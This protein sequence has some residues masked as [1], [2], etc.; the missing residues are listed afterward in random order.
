MDDDDI[1]ET[2]ET[3]DDGDL[4]PLVEAAVALHEVY[5]ALIDGGF[6][7]FEA[8]RMLAIVI[9]EQGIGE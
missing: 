2:D 5:T 6:D 9:A 1:E 4:S 7:E 3:E 8:L